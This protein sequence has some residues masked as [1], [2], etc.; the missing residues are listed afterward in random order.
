[1]VQKEIKILGSVVSND[2][3]TP[4]PDKVKAIKE[5]PPPRTV[6]EMRSFLGVTN[7]CREYAITLK[8]L[9]DLLKGSK[10]QP[11]QAG[12]D[13]RGDTRI[14]GDKNSVFTRVRTSPA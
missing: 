9:F 3:I 12:M 8:P 5:L 1:M 14:Y 13:T 4:D 6:R 2:K 11:A 10:K 7:Y